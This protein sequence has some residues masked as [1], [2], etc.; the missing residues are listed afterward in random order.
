MQAGASPVARTEC[1]RDPAPSTNTASPI[2]T[3]STPSSSIRIPPAA[4]Y[5]ISTPPPA[6]GRGAGSFTD[7]IRTS[8]DACPR[9][10]I[11]LKTR[12]G[13][14]SKRQSVRQSPRNSNGSNVRSILLTISGSP[15]RPRQRS[16]TPSPSSSMK[17]RS[18]PG[19]LENGQLASIVV[20]LTCQVRAS[21]PALS[22]CDAM[23]RDTPRPFFQ[24][25]IG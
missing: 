6:S 15:F 4:V 24:A 8:A 3:T 19:R 5:A 13:P 21:K 22:G 10:V 14:P 23:T 18:S 2:A 20:V 1:C 25:R 11:T 7:R 12:T 9:R 16:S 17:C